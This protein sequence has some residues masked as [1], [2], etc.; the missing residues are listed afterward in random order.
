ML[1]NFVRFE[2]STAITIKY[3]VFWEV[4]RVAVGRT[5]VSEECASV[6]TKCD[7]TSLVKKG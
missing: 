6:G 7:Y 3:A 5:D 1:L 2:V 4:T